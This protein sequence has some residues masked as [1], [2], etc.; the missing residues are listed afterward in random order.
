M[1]ILNALQS[2]MS[3][4]I[5]ISLG[6]YLTFKG[7][8]DDNTSKLFARLVTTISLPCLMLSNLL[9]NFTRE[10]LLSSGNGLIVPFISMV[11]CYLLAKIVSHLIK[12]PSSRR[13]VFEVMFFISNTIFIGLPVNLALFGEVSVPYVLLYY[14]SNTVLFWTIGIYEIGKDGDNENLSLISV[15]NLKRIFSPPLLGFIVAIIFILL[16]INPPEFVMDTCRYLGNLTTP[17]SMLFIGITIH[18]VRLRDIRFSRDMLALIIGRFVVSPLSVLIISYFIRIPDMARNVFIIQASMPV[19]TQTAII[20]RAYD[21]DYEY[22][23]VMIS[24]TTILSALFIPIY[25]YLFTFL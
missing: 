11:I 14:I 6:Y 2:I 16:K 24:I 15:E 7:W 9:K 1:V 17:L 21:S 19:M 25:M 13:G 22:A 10:T 5:M 23:A 18:S 3:I 4:I 8:F 12:V 20:S